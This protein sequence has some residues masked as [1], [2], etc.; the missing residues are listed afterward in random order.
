MGAVRLAS[1]VKDRGGGWVASPGSMSGIVLLVC[2]L[3]F[4][5]LGG[6]ACASDSGSTTDIDMSLRPASRASKE[7]PL[8]RALPTRQFATLGEGRVNGRRWGVYTFQK[9]GQGRDRP[10]VEDVL[11]RSTRRSTSLQTGSPSCGLLAPERPIP[12]ISET[13]LSNVGGVIVG[14][15]LSP[16]VRHVDLDVQGSGRQHL[17]TRSLS[18]SQ[19][20]KA[21]VR[22]FRYVA[23]AFSKGECL[24]QTVGTSA[25]GETLFETPMG[26]CIP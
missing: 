22:Q 14:M 8:W 19:A 13:V 20:R 4:G 15:T 23:V 3:W 25:M 18:S 17:V 7:V 11:E 24:L 2:T 16:E 26:E 10:C 1:A 21:H 6:H 12:V 9:K 5:L